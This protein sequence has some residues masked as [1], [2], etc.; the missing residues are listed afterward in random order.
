MGRI[1]STAVKRTTRTL[2]KENDSFTESF[3]NNKEVLKAYTL[4]D[5]CTRNKIAGYLARL[6]KV[7]NKEGENPS[8]FSEKETKE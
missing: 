7:E 2:L 3:E 6:K 8:S 5:K 1:K 4:P